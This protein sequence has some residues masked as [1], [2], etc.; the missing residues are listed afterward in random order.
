MVTN[1]CAGKTEACMSLAL[2]S[3]ELFDVQGALDPEKIKIKIK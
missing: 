3:S 2:G 1:S